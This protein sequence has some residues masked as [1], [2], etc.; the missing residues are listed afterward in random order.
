MERWA[1]LPLDIIESVIIDSVH[2]HAYYPSESKYYNITLENQ[3]AA[4]V[5]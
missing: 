1:N 3:D 2:T 4:I 5:K